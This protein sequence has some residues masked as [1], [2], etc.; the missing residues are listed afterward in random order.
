MAR[1]RTTVSS[2]V[3]APIGKDLSQGDIVTDIPWGLIGDPVIICRPSDRTSVAGKAKYNSL[4]GT[5][6][7]RAFSKPPEFVHATAYSGTVV[8]LWHDCQIDKFKNQ[9]KQK[10]KWF[11]AVAP[12]MSASQ[13]NAR[14]AEAIATGQRKAFFPLPASPE[15]KVEGPSCYID[16]RHIW[17]VKQTLLV[18]RTVTLSEKTKLALIYHLFEFLTDREIPTEMECPHCQGMISVSLIESNED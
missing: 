15:L 6:S 1:I 2:G 11:T 17:P 9:G 10:K 3:F 18:D 5:H 8:V 4:S 16:L 12:I 7:P 14:D 13:L